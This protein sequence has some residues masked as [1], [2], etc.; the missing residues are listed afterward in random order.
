[1]TE[2]VTD[3]D[4]FAEAVLLFEADLSSIEIE[5]HASEFEAMVA[6]QTGLEHFAAGV[7]NGVFAVVGAALSLS[8]MVFF[9]F[10]VDEEGTVD[11]NFNLPL[12]YLADNAGPGPDLG[13]G[14]VRLA[15]RGQC[16]VPWHAVN[17]W[18]PLTDSEN[19]SVQIVQKTIWRNRL[20]LRP[21]TVIDRVLSD[22]LE[23]NENHHVDGIENHQLLESRL[24]ETFGDEG[25]VNLENLIRQHNDRVTQVSDKYRTEI[26]EQQQGYLDQIRSCREEIQELKAALRHEQQR[27]R[28]LQELLR[29]EP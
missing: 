22:A 5:L 15:C 28:R 27:S 24:T 11:P 12:R 4:G 6:G 7:V 8:S 13:A 3:Q 16:P 20:G 26:Q 19:G 14:I 1:M 21:S 2:L 23:L 29:G 9:T 18:E 10:R 17:L 25:K